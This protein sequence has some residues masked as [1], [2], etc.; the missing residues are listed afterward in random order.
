[1]QKAVGKLISLSMRPNGPRRGEHGIHGR[2]GDGEV[3]NECAN[4]HG[5][6]GLFND[7]MVLSKVQFPIENVDDPEQKEGGPEL[8]QKGFHGVI[9]IGMIKFG[10]SKGFQFEMIRE[11]VKEGKGDQPSAHLTSHAHI[12]FRVGTFSQGPH[13]ETDGRIDV[14]TT[15]NV[16]GRDHPDGMGKPGDLFAVL[17]DPFSGAKGENDHD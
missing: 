2:S 16:I 12:G 9:V 4:G 14:V 15:S 10:S 7:V 11:C 6:Q 5:R 3:D 17:T 1:M 8:A 13:G